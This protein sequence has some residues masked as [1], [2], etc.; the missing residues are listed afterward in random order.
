MTEGNLPAAITAFAEALS[1]WR[2]TP[3]A[4]V[5]GGLA[6]VQRTNYTEQWLEVLERWAALML[7]RDGATEVVEA[8][9]EPSTDHPL[10]EALAN[11]LITALL[12]C[13]RVAEAQSRYEQLEDILAGQLSHESIAVGARLTMLSAEHLPVSP[14]QL[15][16]GVRSFAGRSEE[17]TRLRR[18]VAADHGAPRMAILHGGGGVGKTGLAVHFALEVARLFPDGQLFVDLRGFG[19]SEDAISVQDALGRLLRGLGVSHDQLPDQALARAAYLRTLLADK[20]VLLVLDNAA[21]A[22][23]VRPLLPGSDTCFVLVTS[24]NRMQG[25]LVSDGALALSVGALP[26][27]DALDLLRGVI[28]DKV[29][30]E[31]TAARE[32]VR[33]CG[34]WPLP[35]RVAGERAAMRTRRTLAQLADE[36]GSAEDRLDLLSTDDE[37]ATARAVFSWSYHRL[38]PSDARMFRLLG[39]Y[40]G[41]EISVPAAAA[42][43][44]IGHSQ[45]RQALEA[46]VDAHLLDEFS[47]GRYRMHDLLRLYALERFCAEEPG[48]MQEATVR[49]LL[50]WYLRGTIAADTWL[51][52]T[53]RASVFEPEPPEP[54]VIPPV[55]GNHL[56]SAAW[57]DAELS[58]MVAAIQLA[59][60]LGF[61]AHAWQITHFLTSYFVLRGCFLEWMETAD[62]ALQQSRLLHDEAVELQCRYNRLGAYV[63]SG[64]HAEAL[65]QCELTLADETTRRRQPALVP[66]LLNTSGTALLA[67]GR[68]DEAAARFATALSH[69][70]DASPQRPEVLTNL[71][72]A[73]SALGRFEESMEYHR[74]ALA[75]RQ[76]SAD[77]NGQSASLNGIGD[78]YLCLDDTRAAASSYVEAWQLAEEVGSKQ[79]QAR[80]LLGLG[81]CYARSGRLIQAR[82]VLRRSSDLYLQIG[83]IAVYEVRAEIDRLGA[84]DL[85]ATAP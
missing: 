22:D 65:A 57:C 83:D 61:P 58:N 71:G 59:A 52:P 64:R 37:H 72:E 19:P 24:R 85:G 46:L 34:A 44:A 54:G 32:L 29:D 25:L 35:L 45:A 26:E 40:P 1:L 67:L 14:A 16:H 21:D 81:R 70:K 79:L 33:L 82:T 51:F 9:R 38:A 4:G 62:V 12:S 77:V 60:D 76:A 75:L 3:L 43:A 5:A 10:R 6:Q 36:L 68:A 11:Q 8:L 41:G 20:R 73:C 18:L 28:G 23:Q 56:A 63:H 15:P 13:G 50:D 30:A 39:R 47:S 78:T 17:L 84:S 31:P 2:G 66:F 53:G 80:S 49:R 74:Q 7:I 27:D 55:F 48:E 42:L 69:W